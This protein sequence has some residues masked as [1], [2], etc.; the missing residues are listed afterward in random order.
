MSHNTHT[1]STVRRNLCNVFVSP[2]STLYQNLFSTYSN[3]ALLSYHQWTLS[4]GGTHHPSTHQECI[5]AHHSEGCG[6]CTNGVC[7]AVVALASNGGVCG[8]WKELVHCLGQN[9]AV[10]CRIIV[11]ASSVGLL[12]KEDDLQLEKAL[13]SVA[14]HASRLMSSGA[15]SM[16]KFLCSVSFSYLVWS[17]WNSQMPKVTLRGVIAVLI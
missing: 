8:I 13:L 2:V 4:S 17:K 11:V 3:D 1:D 10:S 5:P 6:L 15:S 12:K 7:I 16:T 9:A 14:I